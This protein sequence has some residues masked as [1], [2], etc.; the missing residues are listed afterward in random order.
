MCLSMYW[1]EKLYLLLWILTGFVRLVVG[2]SL[3]WEAVMEIIHP[4]NSY[5]NIPYIC[6]T[7]IFGIITSCI[8]LIPAAA[9]CVEVFLN[10]WKT[11]P[12]LTP[13]FGT[14]KITP[15]HTPASVDGTD[16]SMV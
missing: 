5:R 1:T 11:A 16:P 8:F 14:V 3:I 15:I 6:L 10:W 2:G 9:V 7:M 12:P 13:L 4:D